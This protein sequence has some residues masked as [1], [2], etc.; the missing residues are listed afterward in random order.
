MKQL[1]FLILILIPFLGKSQ[2]ECSVN[3]FLVDCKTTPTSTYNS[4]E[5]RTIC[6]L[7]GFYE[8]EALVSTNIYGSRTDRQTDA[9]GFFYSKMIDGRWWVIDPEGYLNI[10]KAVNAISTGTGSTSLTAYSSKFGNSS[11]TWMTKTMEYLNGIGFYCAGSWSTTSTIISNPRQATNPLAYTL[12]L[13]W[14]SGYGS[15]RTVQQ[16]GNMGYPNDAIFVF[17]Q[18]FVDYCE[19][20]AKLLVSN[21]NDKNLFGYFTDNELP[22]YDNSLNKFLRLGKKSITDVNYLATKKWLAD[23]NYT[24]ADTVNSDIQK[25]FLGYVGETYGLIVYR[26]IKKYD[27]NHMVLG[28]RVNVSEARNNKYF[29]Q[30]IGKYVDILAVNYY[31]VWTPDLI[32]M[33]E[34]GKNLSKPFMVTEFYT[35]GEDSGLGNTTGGGWVVKT[36]KDRGYAYQN[37]TLALLESKYCVGWQWFKYMDNDP[38]SPSDPSNIDG[39][40][41]LVKIDYEPYEPL[42]EKMKDLNLRAYNLIDYFDKQIKNT[43][44]IYPEADAYYRDN[45]NYGADELLG[46]KNNTGNKRETFLRF[47]LTGQ[48]TN[49]KAAN[50]YLSV[51][52]AGDSGMTFKAEFVSD[53]SWTESSI[54]G[55][56]HP[57]GVYEIANWSNDSNV[58]LD[59]KQPVIETIGT[60]QKLSIKLSATKVGTSQTEYASRENSSVGLRPRIEIEENGLEGPADA[61]QLIDLMVESKRIASFNPDVFDYKIVVP[62]ATPEKPDIQFLLPNSSM[63]VEVSGPV[64]IFSNS[65]S[66]RTAT[67]STTSADGLKHASYNLIFEPEGGI[68]SIGEF[69]VNG[70]DD[71]GFKIY[72]NPVSKNSSVIVE[73]AT[74]ALEN[75]LLSISDLNGN[76]IFQQRINGMKYVLETNGMLQ[77]GIYFITILNS[78]GLHTKKMIVK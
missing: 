33:N 3:G 15:G 64:N 70:A 72:P 24:E 54:T 52:R 32:S 11:S 21:K 22:F 27:P 18:G 53:D 38:T 62:A 12:I 40:K 29:M 69:P 16:S 2:D 73:S 59:V 57:D 46:I 67:I 55:A 61:S 48:S 44:D 43:I 1:F 39:N 71:S 20:K 74:N 56:N 36:Q 25:Q 7:P 58:K 35:K 45:Q 9:T 47:D 49:F 10:C 4:Y 68:T 26:A 65:Q 66:D 50:L 23:H 77:Q 28:P 30:G 13:N 42:V 14:M 60:D 37:Y 6:Q 76:T 41:G 34:W 19:T 75:N 5:T 8:S 17:E 78:T 51:L 63:I 31:G